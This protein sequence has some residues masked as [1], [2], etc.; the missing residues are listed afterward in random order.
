VLLLQ[1][2]QQALHAVRA[3]KSTAF[4]TSACKEG[5][6]ESACP[7]RCKGHQISYFKSMQAVR[8][9]KSNILKALDNAVKIF[10]TAA[11]PMRS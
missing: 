11:Q 3:T 2:Q 6:A 7:F 10:D 1:W 8:A 5:A 4:Q 9:T